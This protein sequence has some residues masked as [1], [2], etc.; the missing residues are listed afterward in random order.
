MK[1]LRKLFLTG[2]VVALTAG[3]SGCGKT[4]PPASIPNPEAGST[5]GIT[6]DEVDAED[7]QR[8]TGEAINAAAKYAEQSKDEYQAAMAKKLEEL[9]AKIDELQ[10]KAGAASKEA[11]GDA[12][13]KYEEAMVA[14]KEKR[15]AVADRLAELKDSSA[16]AWK[17][18][19]AGN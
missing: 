1:S 8:E 11:E 9:D 4:L 7:V 16:D 2:V 6:P 18:I 14:L 15:R 19:A 5:T 17:N 3:L 12:N 10:A 13:R